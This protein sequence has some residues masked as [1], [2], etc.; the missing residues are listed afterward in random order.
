MDARIQPVDEPEPACE[1]APERACEPAELNLCPALFGG[2]RDVTGLRHDFPLVL[3]DGGGGGGY[4]ESLS[5]I[6]N[7]ILREIA[8]E[9]TV[10][11]RTRRHMLRLETEIRTLVSGGGVSGGAAGSLSGLWTKAEA[12]MLGREDGAAREAL[13]ET[14]RLARGVR[15][16]DGA[17]IGCGEATAS[18]LATHAW[19]GVEREKAGKFRAE[20]DRLIFR[21]SDILKADFMKS[22]EARAPERLRR[23]IGAAFEAEFDFEEMSRVLSS[24]APAEKLP[25]TRRRRLQSLL[26]ILESQ[27][28][29]PPPGGGVKPYSFAFSRCS[30][31]LQAFQDRL[32]EMAELIKAISIAGLE[33]ENRYMEAKHDRYFASFDRNS[34]GLEDLACFPSYLVCLQGRKPGAAERDCLIRILASDM[35]I[36]IVHQSDDI[37]DDLAAGT[38]QFSSGAGSALIAGMAVGLNSAYVLQSATA[39]LYGLRDRIRDALAFHGPALINVYAG[40]AAGF[41]GLPAYIVSAAA[42]DSR[43]FPILV[44]DPAAGPDWASRFHV[45]DNPQ[46]HAAW[47]EFHLGFEDDELQTHSSEIAFTFADYAA[48]DDRMAQYLVRVPR[49]EWGDDMVPLAQYLEL[50]Q[51]ARTASTPYILMIDQ[52]DGLH[53]IKVRG[54]LIDAARHCAGRWRSLQELGG[55]DNSHAA[56]LLARER[57]LWDRERQLLPEPAPEIQPTEQ[58]EETEETEENLPEILFGEPS[59]DTLRCTTCNECTELNNRMFA[60]NENQQAYIKDASAGSFKDLVEAAEQCQVCIIHPGKPANPDEPNLAELIERAEL[61]N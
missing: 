14:L 22:S 49:A 5:G 28:F 32:P 53:R 45:G 54:R 59:I 41:S 46:S 24:P 33:I 13:G 26:S 17:V 23:S 19:T 12:A 34:L 60:Y 2:Y 55:I 18:T 56:K 36:K 57:E 43:A 52:G 6:V 42:T 1:P 50:D 25:E 47:P 20:I 40:P 31:A 38:V 30:K 29:C 16:S 21:L 37:L 15:R 10:G 58:V 39:N 51:A 7:A 35:P 61:F 44:Y 48:C 4:V 27:R 9:G 11:E 3:V 8:P